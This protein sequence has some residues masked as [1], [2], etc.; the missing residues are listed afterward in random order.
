MNETQTA[1]RAQECTSALPPEV[2]F[3]FRSRQTGFLRKAAHPVGSVPFAYDSGRRFALGSRL[4]RP[5]R[6]P[7][8]TSRTPRTR[9]RVLPA[10]AGQAT[11]GRNRY[12]NRI[13]GGAN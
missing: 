6:C 10:V 4:P 11:T 3:L 13:H 2:L 1:C 9:K 12:F 7:P 5:A 8:S